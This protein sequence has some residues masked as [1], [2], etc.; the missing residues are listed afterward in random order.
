MIIFLLKIFSVILV[1]Y[2]AQS[3]EN[4][5]CS[6]SF[7]LYSER[8]I[9]D[10]LDLVVFGNL[11]NETHKAHTCVSS[12]QPDR[13]YSFNIN[14]PDTHLMSFDIK[15][16]DEN[17][18]NSIDSVLALSNDCSYVLFCND[19]FDGISSRMVGEL[20]SGDYFLIASVYS[21]SHKNSTFKL[22]ISFRKN[23]RP[24]RPPPYGS[25]NNPGEVIEIPR[26]NFI[27]VNY[28]IFLDQYAYLDSARPICSKYDSADYIVKLI[29]PENFET[30]L[31]IRSFSY[32]NKFDTLIAITDS[33][34][35]PLNDTLFCNDDS[36]IHAGLG[37]YVNG[38]LSS[39]EYKLVYSAYNSNYSG[40]FVVQVNS[41]VRSNGPFGDYGT[42]FNP[43]SLYTEPEIP[44]EGLNDYVV[45]GN[46][47]NFSSIDQ[48]IRCATMSYSVPKVVYRFDIPKNVEMKYDIQ[49]SKFDGTNKMDTIIELLNE[50]CESLDFYHP[51]LYCNDDSNPPGGVSSRLNGNLTSGSYKMIASVNNFNDIGSYKIKASF[52]PIN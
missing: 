17:D 49:M 34:C 31:E 46:L 33:N 15:M 41:T 11:I 50:Q 19:D 51:H 48:V 26:N 27:N 12:D 8:V 20:D 22:T 23:L 47:A 10:D 45:F 28:Y 37:S 14:I 3:L 29:V 21:N 1:I 32:S 25:C 16:T 7:Q 4:S 30:F 2:S 39:G 35:N 24:T 18:G 36:P 40:L 52:S 43:I 9:D 13:L 6:E 42:C 44:S 38:T 5:A